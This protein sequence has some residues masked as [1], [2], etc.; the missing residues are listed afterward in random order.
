M[1]AVSL[2]G[3]YHGKNW[4]D[5]Q[6]RVNITKLLEEL[7]CEIKVNKNHLEELEKIVVFGGGNIIQPSLWIF[8]DI[9]KLKNKKLIMLNI[10]ITTEAKD[11]LPKLADL[12]CLWIVRD[13]YSVNLL[14]Q[15]NITNVIFAPDICLSSFK[16]TAIKNNDKILITTF[17]YYIFH[18]IF[19]NDYKKKIAAERA[20]REITDFLFWMLSF[21]W[22]V[23][24]VPL[25]ISQHIDDR[26]TNSYAAGLLQNKVTTIWD[27]NN[28]INY[29]KY[30]SFILSTRY[31]LSIYAL[32]NNIPFIDIIHHSKN[33]NLHNDIGLKGHTINYYTVLQESLINSAILAENNPD[34]LSITKSLRV[35]FDNDWKI[36]KEKIRQQLIS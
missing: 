24:L 4:G 12:N 16:D 33:A 35:K 7:G 5:E 2:I 1:A 26:I 21:D 19:S 23:V 10:G 18:N 29:L 34:F 36:A 22:Q 9:N 11:L 14:S 15:N 8:K 28:L 30:S 20:Y 25:Q 17:N 32:A 27:N 3:F 13:K 31:H 6:L